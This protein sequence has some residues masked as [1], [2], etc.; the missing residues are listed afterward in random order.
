MRRRPETSV[1]RATPTR[2]RGASLLFALI[3]LMAMM[4][5]ALALV[6]SVNTGAVLLGNLGSKQDVTVVGDQAANQA[7][8][9]FTG[10]APSTLWANIPAAGYYASSND[11]L[12]ATAQ[13]LASGSTAYAASTLIDWNGNSCNGVTA[14]ACLTPAAATITDS[15]GAANSDYSASYVITRLC[16]T[17]GNPANFGMNCL[18]PLSP[19][20]PQAG[21]TVPATTATARRPARATASTS[22]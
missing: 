17:A 5:A 14:V 7:L 4:L 15:S 13:Q 16:A 11:P 12:A 3:T 6:S 9:F 1:L 18:V 22:A 21:R 2:Q 20:V 19:S 10:R 8:G